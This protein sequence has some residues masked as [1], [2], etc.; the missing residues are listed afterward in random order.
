[1]EA[2]EKVTSFL[3]VIANIMG[4]CRIYENLYSPGN[5]DSTRPVMDRLRELYDAVLKFIAEAN[6]YFSTSSGSKFTPIEFARYKG[7]WLE[8]PPKIGAYMG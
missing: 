8:V 1:M 3:E 6:D 4:S 7:R 2:F 5:L